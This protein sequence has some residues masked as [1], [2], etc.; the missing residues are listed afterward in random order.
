MCRTGGRRCPSH[1]NPEKIA[2]RNTQRR[3]QYA[4]KKQQSNNNV[5]TTAVQIISEALTDQQKQYF[6]NS[7][8]TVDGKLI[9]LYHGASVDFASFDPTKLGRGN[10]SWGNGF[11]FTNHKSVAEGYAQDS[12]SETAN[13]K[14]FYLNLTS[15]MYVDGKEKMS[16]NDVTFSSDVVAKIL[17]QHPQAYRQ[18]TDDD[19]GEMSFLGDYCEKYWAKDYHTKE[20]ID[21]MIDEVAE[22][23]LS[24]ASWVEL[25]VMYGRDYG[26]AFLHAV[27]KESG[28]DGVVVDFGEGESKHYI[29]WFPNQMKLTKNITPTD[30]NKF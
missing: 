12:G 19:D 14:E 30:D 20:E 18:P 29:A 16:L 2:L 9:P 23:H 11:Y 24:E 4:L 26:S 27:S 3:T 15:P 22:E 13:V 28:Y 6:V 5:A 1:S 7:K 8:A 25:E 10:D 17:K 21:K